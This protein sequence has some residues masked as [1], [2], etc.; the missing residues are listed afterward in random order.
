MEYSQ[1]SGT[2]LRVSRL[3]LGTMTFG[4]QVDQA[5]AT[6]MLERAIEAGI[7]FIDTANVYQRGKAETLRGEAM[8]GK[9]DKLVLAS[10]VGQ[11]MARARRERP[12]QARHS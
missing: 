2:E 7:N 12:V 10:K 3:C 8:R 6:R 4:R 9:R 1:L 11:R 5:D